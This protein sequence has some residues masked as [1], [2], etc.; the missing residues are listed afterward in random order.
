MCKTF[1]TGLSKQKTS[2]ILKKN[3]S[4]I[5]ITLMGTQV[6]WINFRLRFMSFPTF[7]EKMKTAGCLQIV[8]RTIPERLVLII[9]FNSEKIKNQNSFNDFLQKIE[10]V[11]AHKTFNVNLYTHVQMVSHAY[12]GYILRITFNIGGKCRPEKA[13]KL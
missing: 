9:C 7:L 13:G 3:G 1:S 8:S 6:F 4:F 2:G 11:E 10:N 12:L 5:Y